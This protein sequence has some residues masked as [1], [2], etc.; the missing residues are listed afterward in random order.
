MGPLAVGAEDILLL[1]DNRVPHGLSRVEYRCYLTQLL[2]AGET[3]KPETEGF[4]TAE[5]AYNHAF[6][7]I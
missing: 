4:C 5:T 7:T 1:D 3:L 2:N 6:P